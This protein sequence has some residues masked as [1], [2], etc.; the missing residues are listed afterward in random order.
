MEVKILNKEKNK[1]RLLVKGETHTLL[2]L[3]ADYGNK[4]PKIKFIGYSIPHPLKTEAELNLQTIDEDPIQ[5]LKRQVSK[6]TIDLEQLQKVFNSVFTNNKSKE[7]G[8]S[9]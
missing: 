4:D 5:A 9:K 1:L 6:A 7:K 8:P 2:N 3:I